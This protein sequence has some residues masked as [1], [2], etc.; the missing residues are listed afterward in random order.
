MQ[1]NFPN[2]LKL[3]EIQNEVFITA[4]FKMDNQQSPTVYHRELCSLLCGSLDWVGG[5]EGEWKHEYVQ[6][7]CC[8]IHL[9]LSQHS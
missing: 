1:L 7:S 6:L 3:G 8:A 4:I 2:A 9:K 5:F